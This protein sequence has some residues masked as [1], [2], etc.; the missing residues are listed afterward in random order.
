ML[1]ASNANLNNHRQFSNPLSGIMEHVRAKIKIIMMERELTV[2]AIAS[3]T[4]QT[5]E[6]TITPK[7]VGNP[8]MDKLVEEEALTVMTEVVVIVLTHDLLDRES[9]SLLQTEAVIHPVR[10]EILGVVLG[11]V[12][13][14]ALLAHQVLPVLLAALLAHLIHKALRMAMTNLHASTSHFR[15]SALY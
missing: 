1:S 9:P 13:I 2:G 8:I 5:N 10:D 6:T 7:P 11:E 12:P 4:D 15:I 3:M 14:E